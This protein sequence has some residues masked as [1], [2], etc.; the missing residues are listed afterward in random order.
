MPGRVELLVVAAE[1]G[2]DAE[3]PNAVEAL[4][5]RGLAGDRYCL[6]EPAAGNAAK[7]NITLIEASA[8]EHLASLGI[9][10][11]GSD[12]R[13]N[14]VV[15]GIELNGLVGGEFTIGEV[16]CVATELCDP[17]SYLE[18]RTKPGVLRGLV[19]RGGIRARIVDGGRIALGD[20]VTPA[21]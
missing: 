14:V 4:A 13:R 19:E 11:S 15:S 6:A 17:C 21:A 7:G 1:H 20:E 2:G 3:L 12:V 18:K 9:D 8:L 16:R 5:G 10:A